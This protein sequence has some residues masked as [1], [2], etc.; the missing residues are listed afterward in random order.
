[1]TWE[2]L[3]RKQTELFSEN[4]LVY[5]ELLV[6]ASASRMILNYIYGSLARSGKVIPIERVGAE[7]EKILWE[8]PKDISKGRMNETELVQLIKALIT[9]E[10]YLN[11]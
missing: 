8:T 11:Q 4:H 7:N 10:Y 3:G 1:M 6:T 9:L 5:T 2:E